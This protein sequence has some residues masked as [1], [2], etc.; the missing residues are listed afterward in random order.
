MSGIYGNQVVL[1][2]LRDITEY[3]GLMED[4][5]KRLHTTVWYELE[6]SINIASDV[7]AGKIL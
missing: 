6:Y 1:G 3:A 2:V 4:A 7:T 5:E